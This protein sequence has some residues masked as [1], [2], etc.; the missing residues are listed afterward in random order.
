MDPQE[1]AIEDNDLLLTL[2]FALGAA[3]VGAFAARLLRQSLVLGYVLAGIAIGAYTPGLVVNLTSVEEL[4]DIGVIFLMFAIG[5][6]LSFSD[7]MRVGP[8]AL[9]GANI[10]VLLMIGIGFL[11]G[12]ALGWEPMEALFFGA[13]ISNSS[14][15][16]LTKILGERGEEDSM[17]S[18][19]A[20]A[21]STVQDFGTVVLVVVLSTMANGSESQLPL[22]LAKSVGLAILFLLLVVPLGM[23]ILPWAFE[24]LAALGSSE[25]FVLS[26][27]GV[28]L[29]VAALSDLFGISIALGAFVGGILVGR[30]DLSH[31]VLGQISPLR[32][33]FAGLFFVSVGMLIDPVLIAENLHLV[34]LTA[35][36]IVVV[37]GTL[38]GVITL[39]F[40]YRAKTAV[41]SGVI[42][43]QCAEFSF[44]L[45][46]VGTDVGAVSDRVF[47]LMLAAAAVSIVAAPWA[48]RAVG[49]LGIW[50]E[51][52]LPLSKRAE[53]ADAADEGR[54]VGHAILCGYGRVGRVVADSMVQQAITHVVI[55]QDA[56]LV[57]AMRDRGALALQGSASNPVLLERAGIRK[58]RVLVV[59]LPDP[60]AVRQVL[61]LARAVNPDMSIVVR[62]HSEAERRFLERRGADQAVLG[63]L[64]LALEMSRH[65]LI[66]FGVDE[67][68]TTLLLRKSRRENSSGG[69]EP[70]V[71]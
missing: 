46:R 53:L 55:E 31:Q 4:A 52:Q 19:V 29:G 22:E 58:A 25:V 24:R 3:G 18:R 1:N 12:I 10:Q 40:G 11:T 54:L 5:V 67:S 8:V 32:D 26:A 13:V 68:A 62:T 65:A 30:S 56:G 33:I 15:T 16:V 34:L 37:K 63:E 61:D 2:V 23:L 71:R 9:I 50:L 57:Q 27:A 69:L 39:G 7:M 49:P 45:A 6:Q 48:M 21:W 66:R 44:L 41:L 60:I 14:S 64:E 20:L 43:G 47:G 51:R 36:L 70:G 38:S 35:L 17:H 42:L 28:A 59:A